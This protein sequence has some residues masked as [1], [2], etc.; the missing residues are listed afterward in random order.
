MINLDNYIFG[1]RDDNKQLYL[2]LWYNGNKYLMIARYKGTYY[3]KYMRTKN[4]VG[5]SRQRF[6]IT[7]ESEARAWLIDQTI[8]GK[9]SQWRYSDQPYSYIKEIIDNFDG[10][11]II[12]QIP[13][14]DQIPED[15]SVYIPV[16][17][18]CVVNGWANKDGEFWV[19]GDNEKVWVINRGC[20]TNYQFDIDDKCDVI[21]W[22]T[23]GQIN[24]VWITAGDKIW[25]LNKACIDEFARQTG[26]EDNCLV[27]QWNTNNDNNKVWHT[28]D[29]KIWLKNGNCFVNEYNLLLGEWATRNDEYW[30]TKDGQVWITNVK[31]LRQMIGE[32][33]SP[34]IFTGQDYLVNAAGEL[35]PINNQSL[36]SAIT[37]YGFTWITDDTFNSY[38]KIKPD[39]Q[40]GYYINHREISPDN[41]PYA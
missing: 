40:I 12:R 39:G 18:G 8:S 32:D 24:E 2:D 41:R 22:N 14:D 10:W 28:R 35:T 11:I 31:E 5:T 30:I 7:I 37:Q 33:I 9:L 3:G 26:Y 36:R 1:F 16:V 38:F 19:T 25:V 15:T 13:S 6:N 34:I 29:N 21:A 20:I 27:D 17:E 4:M 23:N